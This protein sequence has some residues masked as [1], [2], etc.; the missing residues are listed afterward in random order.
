MHKEKNKF[1][2]WDHHYSIKSQI[3]FKFLKQNEGKVHVIPTP[4][5]Y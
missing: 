2:K 5:L 1:I 3:L 4:I